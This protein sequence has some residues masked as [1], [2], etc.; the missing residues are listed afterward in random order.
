MAKQKNQRGDGIDFLTLKLI[1]A[2]IQLTQKSKSLFGI[3][4][5]NSPVVIKKNGVKKKNTVKKFLYM[6]YDDNGGHFFTRKILWK[7]HL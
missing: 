4:L 5:K 7:R 1:V 3:N 6:G 2:D